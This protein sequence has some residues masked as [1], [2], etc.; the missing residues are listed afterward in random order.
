MAHH[1]EAE[2]WQNICY[3]SGPPDDEQIALITII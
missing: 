2:Q 1:V 3:E